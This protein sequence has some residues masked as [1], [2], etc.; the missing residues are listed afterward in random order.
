MNAAA[1]TTTRDAFLG[2]AIQVAQ[3]V[4]GYRAGLD[5]VLLAASC[6]VSLTV[7]HRVLDCG[8]GVGTVGLCVAH[9]AALAEITLVEREPELV[10][11]ARDNIATNGFADRITVIEADV[12]DRLARAPALATAVETYDH[13]LANPPYYDDQRGTRATDP[14]RA[15]AHAMPGDDLEAWAR[16]MAGLAKPRGTVTMVHRVDALGAILKAFDARFGDLKLMPI[17]ARVGEMANRILIQGVKGSR[18][19]LRILPPL[20]LYGADN[21]A[22]PAVDGILRRGDA[23]A[24]S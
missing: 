16:F 17:Y 12:T 20:V 11:L 15:R 1:A 14:L 8:A 10:R 6:P 3:P 22:T 4:N 13:V 19:P 23:L 7:K 5:A 2:G 9:R 18:A 24:W 21:L